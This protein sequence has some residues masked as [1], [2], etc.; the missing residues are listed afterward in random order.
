[1]YSARKSVYS[2]WRRGLCFDK[3][4][5]ET[6]T[7][8]MYI[9]MDRVEQRVMMKYVFRKAH[10]SKLMHKELVSILQ[11]NAISLSAVKNWLR[12]CKSGDLSYGDDEWPGRPMIS[13]GSAL[14]RFLK[15]FPFANARVMAGHFSVDRATIE[16]ILDRELGLGKFIRRWVPI[17]YRPDNN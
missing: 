4:L 11:D 5:I 3:H 7:H 2:V 10:G 8:G 14:R 9:W 16:S 13:L 17:F 12:R 15:K 6:L 1:M